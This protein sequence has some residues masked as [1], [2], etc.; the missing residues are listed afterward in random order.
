[1]AGALD[2]VDVA[3]LEGEGDGLGEVDAGVFEVV[4]DE[5]RDGDEAGGGGVREV[6]GPLVYGDGAG[7][8]GGGGGFVGLGV[9]GRERECEGEASDGAPGVHVC[10]GRSGGAWR[11]LWVGKCQS[12]AVMR[13]K[14]QVSPLPLRLASLTQDPVEMTNQNNRW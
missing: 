9:E 11:V 8:W 10:D 13:P 7:D 5:E 12:F 2:D 6:A 1:L 3:G 4:V 14:L